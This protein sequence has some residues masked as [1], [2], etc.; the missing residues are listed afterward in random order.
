MTSRRDMVKHT[1]S[2]KGWRAAAAAGATAVGVGITAAA[3]TG[4]LLPLA[5]GAAGIV[6]TGRFA[7]DWLRYR[8]EWGLRF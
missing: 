3:T 6:I 2:R 5:V 8:G 1:A 7:R 4:F